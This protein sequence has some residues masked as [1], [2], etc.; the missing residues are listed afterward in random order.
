MPLFLLLNF[1]FHIIT[2]NKKSW[3][4][5]KRW[6]IVLIDFRC[7]LFQKYFAWENS[8]HW[9]KF[10][11]DKKE[12]LI[13]HTSCFF[14]DEVNHTSC[15]LYLVF[16]WQLQNSFKSCE[17]LTWEER[18]LRLARKW[19]ARATQSWLNSTLCLFMT[20]STMNIVK[21]SLLSSLS[22]DTSLNF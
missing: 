1:T 5:C 18:E 20:G 17:S 8:F 2:M 12:V 10:I 13:S 21:Y 7:S 15:M 9:F 3:R 14:N 11:S 19:V 4:K 6:C 22:Y 16:D